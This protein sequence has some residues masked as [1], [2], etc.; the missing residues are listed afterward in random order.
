[1][2]AHILDGCLVALLCFRFPQVKVEREERLPHRFVDSAPAFPC[3]APAIHQPRKVVFL[4]R[5]LLPVQRFHAYRASRVFLPQQ[6]YKLSIQ[7][8]RAARLPAVLLPPLQCLH[9]LPYFLPLGC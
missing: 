2:P 4:Q 5:F 6:L 7:L 9:L 8:R 3:L 1:M